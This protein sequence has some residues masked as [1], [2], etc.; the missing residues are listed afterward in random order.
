M[1]CMLF[2]LL[3]FSGNYGIVLMYM[4][5][6]TTTIG[7]KFLFLFL[8]RIVGVIRKILLKVRQLVTSLSMR[9]AV[10]KKRRKLNVSCRNIARDMIRITTTTDDVVKKKKRK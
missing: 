4:T 8:S 5:V 3:L 6:T 10:E 7:S 2:F 1:T 9:M